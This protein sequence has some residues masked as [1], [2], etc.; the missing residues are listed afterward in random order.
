VI[1]G[2]KW[3]DGGSRL[4][5]VVLGT[6]VLATLALIAPAAAPAGSR[7][8][9]TNAARNAGI[10]FTCPNAICIVKPDG[11]GRGVFVTAWF[12]SY[13]DRELDARRHGSGVF[14]GIQRYA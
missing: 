12:D 8:T 7:D 2:S 13:G 9:F 10:S 11:S 14:R 6:A 1:I 5:R 4:P 3:S